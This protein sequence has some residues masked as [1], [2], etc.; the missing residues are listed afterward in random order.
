MKNTE[1]GGRANIEISEGYSR[2][3]PWDDDRNPWEK[4]GD[5]HCSEIPH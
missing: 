2:K 4:I 5:S 3:K 1:K